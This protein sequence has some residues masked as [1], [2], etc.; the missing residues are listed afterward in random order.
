MPVNAKGVDTL[1]QA[2]KWGIVWGIKRPFDAR[3]A[4]D[5]N[6]VVRY[7]KALVWL[8]GWPILYTWVIGVGFGMLQWYQTQ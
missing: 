1:W 2:V 7:A 4:G 5:D 8:V 3:K 6:L